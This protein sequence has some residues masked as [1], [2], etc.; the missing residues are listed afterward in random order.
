MRVQLLLC[1]QIFSPISATHN[2]HPHRGFQATP[3]QLRTATHRA[4]VCVLDLVDKRLVQGEAGSLLLKGDL[5]AVTWRDF[6]LLHLLFNSKEGNA[7]Q[8]SAAVGLPSWPGP[9][10]HLALAILAHMSSAGAGAAAARVA[11]LA[12]HLCH[13]GRALVHTPKASL[14]GRQ[15]QCG[16]AEGAR[17]F[18][19]HTQASGVLKA[20][21]SN[22]KI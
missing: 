17:A 14:Q 7:N 4:L 2:E 8:P 19:H 6:L 1:F 16:E 18:F 21:C 9:P 12:L 15:M 13:I 20:C 22:Q 11:N 10:S 5:Q 3:V